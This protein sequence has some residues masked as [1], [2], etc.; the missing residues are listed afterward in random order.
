MPR[1]DMAAG[2]GIVRFDGCAKRFCW[3]FRVN[4]NMQLEC[5]PS[6][7]AALASNHMQSIGELWL[8]RGCT[9]NRKPSSCRWVRRK[10]LL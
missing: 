2:R 6:V 8:S 10:H 3:L 7:E 4:L 1:Q 5:W 9:K